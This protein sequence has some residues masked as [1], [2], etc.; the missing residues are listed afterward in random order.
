MKIA[1]DGPAASGKSS[2]GRAL[3]RQFGCRFVETGNMYRAVALGVLRGL[4]LEDMIID[5]TSDERLMLNG[6]DVTDRLHTAELDQMSSKVAVD[7]QVRAK[8]VALQ[9]KLA[10]R[11][12]VV[13]EGRDIGT[14]VLPDADVKIFLRAGADVRARRRSVERGD[15]D[16]VATLRELRA[17]DERDSTRAV[18]PLNPASDASIIDTDQ[19]TLPQ[20]ISAA[21]NLVKEHLDKRWHDV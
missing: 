5:V 9:R 14:V 3:A 12:D 6:E 1:I 17:R 20:V 11:S 2:V 10:E 8:L 21:T 19:K 18:A 15:R 7:P 13:M 16:P 4:A